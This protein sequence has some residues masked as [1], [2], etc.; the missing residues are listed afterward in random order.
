MSATLAMSISFKKSTTKTNLNHNNR[1]FT[2]K[3]K[4]KNNHINYNRS[5]RNKYLVQ[6]DLKEL[7]ETE[8]ASA[9]EKYNQKQTRSDRKIESYYN[10]IKDSKKTALQQEMIIQVGDKDYYQNGGDWRIGNYILEEW[11][12]S[13]EERNPNLKVFNAVIHNDEASPHLHLNFVPVADGYKQGLEK[14]VSFDKAIKQHDPSLDKT[15]PFAD[16]REKEVN[17]ISELLKEF[18]IDRKIVGTNHY[19][20]VND[21]KVKKDLEREVQQLGKDLSMKKE[22]LLAYNKEIKVNDKLDITA[23]KEFEEVEVESGKK[24]IFGKPKIAKIKKWTNNLIISVDDYKKMQASIKTGK[25]FENRLND[26]LETDILKENKQLKYE[27]REEK[28]KNAS[29]IS[30]NNSLEVEV[31]DLNDEKEDL[32]NEIGN[33]KAEISSVYQCTKSFLKE[34]TADLVAFKGGFRVL[35][36]AIS[37]KL[38]LKGLD[39]HFKKEYD[40]ENSATSRHTLEFILEDLKTKSA[41]TNK[42]DKKKQIQKSGISG[43]IR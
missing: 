26:L 10:H 33:L 9:L 42:I 30:K 35:V 15:R 3:Q 36:Y 27:L 17:L 1:K 43:I 4:D 16:W 20:D 13:F 18:D 12:K 32:T 7:Y 24:T 5:D 40:K 25:H 21:Y 2:E 29:L 8:F 31:I 28:E 37:E 34:H 22:E 6:R 41:E 23:Y 11:F 14:Q 19:K 38:N 39:N